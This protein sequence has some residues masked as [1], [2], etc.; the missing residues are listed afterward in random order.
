MAGED[1][2]VAVE[3]LHVDRHVRDGLRAVDQHAR[4]VAVRHRDHL[5]RR[6]DGAERVRDLGERHEPRARA[7]QLLVLVEEHLPASS[8]GATRSFAPFSAAS[9]CQGTM[10]AW[11]S[12]QVMTISSPSPM[13]RRPQLC[14]T[15]LMP[16]VAPRTKTMSLTELAL[17]KRRTFSR[18]AS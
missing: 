11:C 7:E 12:S 5:G 2:E 17:R 4:A 1:V 13:L 3:R 14:A 9:C 15:R 18:A 10:L 6:R 16:S 8:T